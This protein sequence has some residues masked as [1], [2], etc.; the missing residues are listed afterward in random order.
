[1]RSDRHRQHQQHRPSYRSLVGGCN[2]IHP[3]E[4]GQG[5]MPEHADPLEHSPRSCAIP[6]PPTVTLVAYPELHFTA[7][8]PSSAPVGKASFRVSHR[9]TFA[10][11]T[12]LPCLSCCLCCAPAEFGAG[13][14]H[15]ITLQ[16]LDSNPDSVLLVG[17]ENRT[18]R[19]GGW[20]AVG[21]RS[22]SRATKMGEGKIWLG[23]L[24]FPE[25]FQCGHKRGNFTKRGEG[26]C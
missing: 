8:L 7:C 23:K 9:T 18:G 13:A 2:K 19:M 12:P 15:G 16:V 24:D 4:A 17:W 26:I 10:Q 5:T 1:M 20:L 25:N 21:V 22:R 14:D 6:P 11:L 3:Q